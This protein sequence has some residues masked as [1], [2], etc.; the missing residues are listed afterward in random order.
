M[1]TF[2]VRERGEGREGRG[3]EGGGRMMKREEKGKVGRGGGK[4]RKGKYTVRTYIGRG[5]WKSVEGDGSGV[6][7]ACNSAGT[8]PFFSHSQQRLAMK[9][10]FRTQINV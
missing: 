9:D 6:F 10:H 5:E 3:G 1:A 7:V 2:K 4:K 8:I